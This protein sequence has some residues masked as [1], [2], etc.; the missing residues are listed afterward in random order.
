[1]STEPSL[2][3]RHRRQQ[4]LRRTLLVAG[5]ALMAIIGIVGALSTP[6]GTPIAPESASPPSTAGVNSPSNAKTPAPGSTATTPPVEFDKT[7]ESLTDPSSPW[8][9]VNK[10]RPIPDAAAFVPPDLTPIPADIPNPNG[11][12]LRAGA[13]DALVSMVA[14]AKAEA[15]VQLVAQSGYR[16]YDAQISAY[17]Y[18]TDLYGQAG[19]D[20]TSA[21]PGHSEH[22]TGMA[23]D[24]LDTTSGCGLE[25]GCFGGT[26]AGQW[27]ASNAHRFGWIMRYPDGATPITGYE[28]EPW[29]FRWVGIA[30][31]EELSLS[32][33]KTIEEYFGLS[34]A[35]Q[36]MN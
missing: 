21:R 7:A 2:L 33:I 32:R 3:A 29:H 17:S 19:A 15:G 12:Q 18:Y 16:S 14:A 13:V 25:D 30:L 10:A 24:I 22:Q 27:L 36:Y 28:Y 8:L 9:V 11:H 1:M 4:R 26:V 35:P 31:A 34:P 6:P 20:L 5:L 23:L